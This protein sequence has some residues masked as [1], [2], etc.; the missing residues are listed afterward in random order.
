ME[1]LY[2]NGRRERRERFDVLRGGVKFCEIE[3]QDGV[4]I[5]MQT[6]AKVKTALSGAFYIPPD[7]DL[8]SD[9]IRPMIWENGEWTPLGVFVVA[10]ATANY[11]DDEG[12]VQIDAR[13]CGELVQRQTAEDGFLLSAGALYTNVIPELLTRCGVEN[14]RVYH[15]GATLAT[16]RA[17]WEIGTSY[18]DIVNQLLGEINYADLWFDAEG[19][20][21]VEPP[22]DGT[23]VK[24][25]YLADEASVLDAA[26]TI[27]SS[28]FSSYNVFTAVVSSPDLEAP[29]VATASNDDPLSPLSTVNRGRIPMPVI[30]LDSMAGE[31]ALRE[32]VERLRNQSVVSTQTVIFET[33]VIPHG[34]GDFIYLNHHQAKGVWEETEWTIRMGPGGTM[35][36]RAVKEVT[37]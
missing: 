37:P 2:Q 23:K 25:S 12:S 21:R 35:T 17:D 36:H 18:L 32:Y 11:V 6:G 29:L 13:D 9:M 14:I 34:V 26:Y 1:D 20:A 15:S 31:D 19:C 8:L 33:A 7:V 10:N 16:D 24:H 4:T 3:A 30:R 27:E 5:R 28:A 22:G